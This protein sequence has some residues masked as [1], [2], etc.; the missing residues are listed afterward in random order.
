[1]LDD[2][3]HKRFSHSA[4]DLSIEQADGVMFDCPV[5]ER[6]SVICWRPHVPLSIPPRPGRWEFAGSGFGDLTLHAGSSSIYLPRTA[7]QAHF[8]V[9]GGMVVM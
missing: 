4:V 8:W 7:C 5:C 9:R 1:M 6:H 2:V 3:E